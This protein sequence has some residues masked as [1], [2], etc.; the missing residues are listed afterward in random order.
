MTNKDNL[1]N[2]QRH[3]KK[4]KSRGKGKT[5]ANDCMLNFLALSGCFDVVYASV[6]MYL[7][8]S[9]IYL[10]VWPWWCLTIN[11]TLF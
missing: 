11:M 8:L 4:K 1:I 9:V 10:S 6:C 5:G 3:K 7:M 2:I